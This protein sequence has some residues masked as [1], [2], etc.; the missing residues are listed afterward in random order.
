LEAH[1]VNIRCG[2]DLFHASRE[3]DHGFKG[4]DED[5]AELRMIAFF[6]RF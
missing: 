4:A 1:E 3:A 5:R 6:D 2:S